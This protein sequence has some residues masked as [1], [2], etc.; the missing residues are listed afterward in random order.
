MLEQVS[1][2]LAIAAVTATFAQLLGRVTEETGLAGTIVSTGPLDGVTR[3]SKERQLNL[4]L[5]EIAP[6]AAWRA[7]DLPGRGGGGETNQPVMG[8]DLRYLVTA[9]GQGDDELDAQHLLAQA[10]GLLHANPILTPDQI[11]ATLAAQPTLAASDLADQPNPVRITLQ[12]L[13]LNDLSRLWGLFRFTTYRL[14]V[15]YQA[16]AILI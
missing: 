13:S 3:A 8:L 7:T 11:T 10:L 2:P 4:F 15:G 6:N 5:Y 1:N 16:S 9:Y 12:T 14:S